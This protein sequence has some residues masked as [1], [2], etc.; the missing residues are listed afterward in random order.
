MR[1]ATAYVDLYA[2]KALPAPVETAEGLEYLSP[3]VARLNQF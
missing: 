2:Q 3:I 1:Q